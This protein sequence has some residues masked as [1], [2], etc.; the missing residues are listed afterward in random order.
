ML[1]YKVFISSVQSEFSQERQLVFD[2][3]RND[4]L[5]GQY[6]E[7]FIFEQIA[8]Q[9]AN[10]RQLYLDEAS[11]SQV[12]L[13]LMGKKYGNVL[14]DGISP[15][16][17]EYQAAGE[18]NAWRV[19]FISDLDG[20][21]REDAE[22]RFFRKVQN[23][24]SYRVFSNP[25]VLVSLVK[26]SL[27][28]YLKHKGVIQTLSFDEQTRD[29]ASMADIDAT[30]IKDFL[31]QARQKR[32]F[33][34]AEDSDP[35]TVLRH[36]RLVRQNKPSNGALLMFANDPQYFFPSA[37]VKCAWFL[38]TETVK[39]IEDYKTFEGGVADQISQAT[40]WV[41]SKLSVRFGQ[42]NVEAQNEVE[43]EIPRSVIFET[44]VNAVAHRDYNSTG[45]VQVSVFRNRIVVRNPGTLPVELT[46]A[47]L[48]KEHG[49]YPHNPYLAE[50]LYQMGY[51]EK[52]GTGITEN[53]RRMQEARLLAPEIDLSAEFVTTIW[54]DS[55]ATESSNVATNIGTDI[56]TNDATNDATNGATN[57]ATSKD[58]L[59]VNKRIIDRKVKK[60]VRKRMT[61]QQLQECIVEACYVEHS[62]E[63]LAKLLGKSES[64]IRNRFITNM[65]ADGILL[66]TKPVH[67]SGQTYMTNPKLDK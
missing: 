59:A 66:R 43:F 25:S 63:E 10:P 32:G 28:A 4:E 15:T 44:I 35:I 48:M 2:F 58:Y 62:I 50:V 23:E 31:H 14:P 51:I 6:F 16:E 18:G 9:D 38:G 29:D 49:S 46:K 55:D 45:S 27:Y 56:G 53:I 13:L 60:K 20:Q 54:R 30:K 41:M 19:A 17:K 3:I 47:D 34:L 61:E 52:Y 57:D 40:S 12:Y 65:V 42:R 26:Q 1:K 33:P 8:A 64:H 67:S 24:L 39:P 22:E 37:V 11:S 36:L 7:P 21:Q 5:M